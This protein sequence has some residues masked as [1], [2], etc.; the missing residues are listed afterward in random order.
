VLP[1]EYQFGTSTENTEFS[2]VRRDNDVWA[3]GFTSCVDFSSAPQA[4]GVGVR[5]D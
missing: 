1:G 4:I 2:A 3:S 5:T